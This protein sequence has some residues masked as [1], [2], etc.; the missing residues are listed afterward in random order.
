MHDSDKPKM[1]RHEA[2]WHTHLASMR[3]AEA[4]RKQG[5]DPLTTSALATATAG[6]VVIAG[7]TLHPASQGT[8]WTLQRAAREFTAWADALGMTAAED[9][10]RPETRELIELG[11]A[12]L[13]F[14]DPRAC[15][16]ELECGGLEDMILRAE[17]LIWNLEVSS[18]I[19]LQ[20]HFQSQMERL[21]QLAS[22]GEDAGK[23]SEPVQGNGSSPTPAISPVATPSPPSSVSPPSMESPS[24]EPSGTSASPSPSSCCPPVTNV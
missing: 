6:P 13:I 20:E 23:K 7:F 17:S 18:Q 22:D 12:T 10:E 1:S 3:A 9:P 2:S 16:N 8:I 24:S 19:K 14:C 21:G 11:L 4:A 5:S 15:W